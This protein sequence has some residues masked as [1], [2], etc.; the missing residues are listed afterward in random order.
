[1]KLLI[2]CGIDAVLEMEPTEQKHR[3]CVHSTSLLASRV[4]AAHSRA[5]GSVLAKPLCGGSRFTWIQARLR[6]ALTV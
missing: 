4:I 5:E 2:S 6:V 3:L 1:M